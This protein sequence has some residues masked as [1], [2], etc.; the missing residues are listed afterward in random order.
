MATWTGLGDNTE[1]FWAVLS[2]KPPKR[3]RDLTSSRRYPS[4]EVATVKPVPQGSR[5]RR[6]HVP[7]WEGPAMLIQPAANRCKPSRPRLPMSQASSLN[8]VPHRTDDCIATPAAVVRCKQTKGNQRRPLITNKKVATPALGKN[9][10]PAHHAAELPIQPKLPKIVDHPPSRAR[11]LETMP[12]RRVRR[13]WRRRCLSR[14]W[15]GFS[16]RD[17]MQQGHSSDKMMPPHTEKTT[18]EDVVAIPPA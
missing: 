16:P 3:C 4:H 12:P 13:Q 14:S 18:S 17:P 2:H 8:V 15:T 9:T 5:L 1:L 11:S 10:L 6:H 7:H